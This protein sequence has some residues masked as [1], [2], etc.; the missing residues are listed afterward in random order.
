MAEQ[1]FRNKAA[2]LQAILPRSGPSVFIAGRFN[3]SVLV[4]AGEKVL[5]TRHPFAVSAP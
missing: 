4:W 2:V 1:A 5:A 3:V